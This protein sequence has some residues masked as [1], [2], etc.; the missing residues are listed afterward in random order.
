MEE[1]SSGISKSAEVSRIKDRISFL[2]ERHFAEGKGVYYLSRLGIDLGPDRQLI[3]RLTGQRLAEFIKSEFNFVIDRTGQHNNVL[4][5]VQPGDADVRPLILLCQ[6]LQ[7]NQYY[8]WVM[9]THSA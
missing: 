9:G 6:K 2:V 5:I 7:E 4:H 8:Q 3:E 1:Q